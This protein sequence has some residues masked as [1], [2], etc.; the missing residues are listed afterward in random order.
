M[1]RWFYSRIFICFCFLMKLRR[2]QN[3]RF[4]TSF[5][6]KKVAFFAMFWLFLSFT[7]ENWPKYKHKFK[8]NKFSVFVSNAAITFCDFDQE[9]LLILQSFRWIPYLGE[10]VNQIITIKSKTVQFWTPI[11]TTVGT[12]CPVEFRHLPFVE[13]VLQNV[14]ALPQMRVPLSPFTVIEKGIIKRN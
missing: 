9:K 4:T 1:K 3:T 13:A 5:R 12:I 10:E 2:L 14:P 6:V 7:I 8:T 11:W